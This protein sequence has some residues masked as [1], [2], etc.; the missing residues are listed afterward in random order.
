MRAVSSFA[1]LAALASASSSG[2]AVDP[3][4]KGVLRANP[5]SGLCD[6]VKQAR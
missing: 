6:T 3:L 5:V 2:Q 1:A 4:V